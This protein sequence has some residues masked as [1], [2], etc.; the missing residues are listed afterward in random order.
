MSFEIPKQFRIFYYNFFIMAPK[1][2]SLYEM[3]DILFE[4]HHEKITN[5]YPKGTAIMI[6]GTIRD[7]ACS[8]SIEHCDKVIS[9]IKPNTKKSVYNPERY[10]DE[11][12]YWLTVKKML[13]S[14]Q[15]G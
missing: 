15:I 10:T 14:K 7:I 3:V 9:S 8:A 11:L 6:D 13:K 4:Y 12:G 5:L 1:R 2:P